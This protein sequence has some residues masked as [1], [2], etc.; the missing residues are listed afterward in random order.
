M[1]TTHVLEVLAVIIFKTKIKD[2]ELYVFF[3]R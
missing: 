1:G 3:F 2:S